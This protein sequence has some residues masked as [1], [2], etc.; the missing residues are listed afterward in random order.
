MTLTRPPQTQPSPTAQEGIL[1][2]QSSRESAARTYAR[3]LPIVPVRARGL[4]IEGADGRRYLDCLSGAGSLALGHNH[5]VVL[6]AIRSVLD[7]G[8]PP[9]RARPGHAREGHLHQ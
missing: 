1:R 5:P 3:S 2:R 9:A 8:A 4:T 7:S 6:E